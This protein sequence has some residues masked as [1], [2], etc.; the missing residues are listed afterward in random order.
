[1]EI[2]YIYIYIYSGNLNSW[3]KEKCGDLGV[4]IIGEE[5]KGV[6]K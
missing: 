3:E 5:E 2:I 6:G 4:N 1:M